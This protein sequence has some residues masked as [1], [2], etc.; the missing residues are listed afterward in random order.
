MRKRRLAR[1]ILIFCVWTLLG[2]LSAVRVMIT[3]A[4]SGNIVTWRRALVIAL[5]DWYVWALLA[6]AIA[7]LARRFAIERRSWLRSLLVHI[8]ASLFFSI[9]KMVIE[10]RLLQ[11]LDPPSAQRYPVLQ[12]PS[13]LFTYYAILGAIYAF[14][15]YGKY[16]EHELK[17]SQLQ[18]Q[19]AQAQLQSLKMQLHPHFLFNT[20]HAIS[21]LMRRDVEG[22][23]RMITRLSDLLR[24]TLE[25]VG[26]Q[27]TS[28]RQELEFLERYLEI[29]QTRFRDR[30]QVKMDI[31]PEALD[32][33]VPNLILQPLVENAVRHGIAPHA[34]PGLIEISA[35]LK[36]NKLELQVSDNGAGLPD[37]RRAQVKEGVG[38]G[39]TRARLDQLYGADYLFDL[40]NRDKGGLVVSLTIPFRLEGRDKAHG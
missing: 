5:A 10:F 17:A 29:E 19:L 40:S 7:W 1:G 28:L 16:R 12:F 31:E 20:L 25:N 24:L 4:Y 15:Y 39:N 18:A 35:R 34:A 8:P 13:T 37:A 14:D 27:E 6:P 22:A 36:E 11:W 9:P 30:L 23:E 3:Y 32:A 33:R 21:S 26:A 38:L 2:A